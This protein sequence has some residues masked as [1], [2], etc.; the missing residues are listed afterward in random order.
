MLKISY[1]WSYWGLPPGPLLVTRTLLE[2]PPR[3]A[4]ASQPSRVAL[5]HHTMVQS[6]PCLG[7]C[8]THGVIRG[9]IK[10]PFYIKKYTY[11]YLLLVESLLNPYHEL[12]KC[13]IHRL[14]RLVCVFVGM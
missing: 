12:K 6:T 11:G 8:C 7:Q 1:I 10:S 2:I 14:S 3:V 4:A 9:V 5:I 13:R